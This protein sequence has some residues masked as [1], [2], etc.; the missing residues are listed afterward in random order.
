MN[1]AAAITHSEVE[2][3]E[4][5]RRPTRRA[6]Q[7]LLCGEIVEGIEKINF[8]SENLAAPC[9]DG[10]RNCAASNHQAGRIIT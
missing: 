10:R 3:I 8:V 6:V 7:G 2:C 1:T 4:K 9:F 5:G